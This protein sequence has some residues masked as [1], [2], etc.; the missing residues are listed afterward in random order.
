LPQKVFCSKCGALLYEGEELEAP[1]DVIQRYSGVC[2]KCGK[3]LNFDC[4]NIE[5]H[6]IEEKE[7]L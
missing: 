2:P 6:P 3:T 7:A 5:I 4:E 1:I